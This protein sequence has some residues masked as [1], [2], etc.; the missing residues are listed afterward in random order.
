[1]SPTLKG[2][3]RRDFCPEDQKT[4]AHLDQ[5]LRSGNFHQ[6]ALHIYAMALE[7]LELKG[8]LSVLNVGSG[9]GFFSS[10]IASVTG[11]TGVNHGIEIHSDMV[12]FAKQKT[13]SLNAEFEFLC[14]SVFGLDLT[15]PVGPQYDRIYV[16]AGACPS[17]KPFFVRLLKAG[18]VLVG[19]FGSEMLKIK[20]SDT[21]ELSSEVIAQVRFA[22][23]DDTPPPFKT[24]RFSTTPPGWSP[25]KH[26]SFAL[27]SFHK[28]VQVLL[29]VQARQAR[30]GVGLIRGPTTR[31]SFG[32]PKGLGRM[33]RE[34]LWLVIGFMHRH[35]FEVPPTEVEALRKKLTDETRSR[36]KAEQ[37]VAE[38]E[39]EIR[40]L[41]LQVLIM[42]RSSR[43]PPFM[44]NP[45]QQPPLPHGLSN[46]AL[47]EQLARQEE[48]GQGLTPGPDDDAEMA[49]AEEDEGDEMEDNSGSDAPVLPSFLEVGGE[50]GD[51]NL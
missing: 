3:D 31:G 42:R 18:G 47:I 49:S 22:P 36:I 25:T 33:P 28:G 30:G 5:P 2:V 34:L 29:G 8:G 1:M 14:G 17:S 9:S 50:S 39:D 12:E 21:G 11:V 32:P 38:L 13:S 19:P 7:A 6:S 43:L 35:W 48:E 45:N 41:R 51:E 16:G 46:I 44:D 20:K 10:V 23:L 26:R 15:R 4:Q 37:K 27:P 40:D 24:L